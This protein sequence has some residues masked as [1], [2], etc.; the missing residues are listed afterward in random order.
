M[1]PLILGALGAAALSS[2]A[3]SSAENHK[4]EVEDF[5]ANFTPL[6]GDRR[7][8]VEDRRVPGT[9]TIRRYRPALEPTPWEL[10]VASDADGMEQF[11]FLFH[12]T[13]RK[14]QVTIRPVRGRKRPIDVYQA[15]KEAWQWKVSP[16]P[17]YENRYRYF[18]PE[19]GMVGWFVISIKTMGKAWWMFEHQSLFSEIVRMRPAIP[20]PAPKAP[21]EG[22]DYAACLAVLLSRS[23]SE[24]AAKEVAEARAKA[25]EVAREL[26]ALRAELPEMMEAARRY[27]AS[28]EGVADRLAA[29]TAIAAATRRA[30]DEIDAAVDIDEAMKEQM[31]S[32]VSLEGDRNLELLR[33]A[34][35]AEL[36]AVKRGQS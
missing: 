23:S 9:P 19:E 8:V 30:L 15:F 7:I 36:D 13:F 21:T 10:Q 4:R 28:P 14:C 35:E 5:D 25:D 18:H 3:E 6:P 1:L 16:D 32:I 12:P 22:A 24:A 29:I 26:A 20:A 31:R 33:R 34:V 11:A 2:I 27:A 17:Y